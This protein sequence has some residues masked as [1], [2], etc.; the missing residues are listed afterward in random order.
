MKIVLIMTDSQGTNVLGCYGAQGCRTPNIDRLAEEGVRFERAYTTCPVCSPARGALFTGI[1]PHANGCWGNSMPLAEN[2]RTIGERLSEAGY[3]NAYIGKWHLDAFDYFGTGECPA[4]W[5]ARYWYD[6]RRYLEELTPEQRQRSRSWEPDPGFGAELTFAHRC[7]D[8][9]IDFLDKYADEDFMLVVSYDEPHGPHK[10]PV[11]YARMYDDFVYPRNP[12]V[13]DT[14]ENKPEHQRAWAEYLKIDPGKPLR[15]AT[16]FGCNTFVDHE[17]GRVLDAVSRQAPDAMVIFTSDHGYLL[18]AHRLFG[19][20]PVMYDEATRI[21]LIIRWPGQAAA[22][23]VQQTPTTHIDIVPTVLAAA[24]LDV[25]PVLDGEPLVD[26]L[27]RATPRQRT[28]FMEFNRFAGQGTGTGGLIPIRCAFDGQY[29]LVINLFYTDELY[30]LKADPQELN[31]LIGDPG[32]ASVRTRLHDE[33]LQWMA[34]SRD[35]FAGWQW[36]ARPWRGQRRDPWWQGDGRKP[37]G[38]NEIREDG[39]LPR[40]IDYR[41]GLSV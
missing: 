27:R 13:D 29:K 15:A 2:I 20:G 16:Y 37:R 5:D 21:P 35:P 26:E 32:L 25:P 24:G 41:T 18:N 40:P 3:H 11:E 19:K 30:N 34:D 12:N 1:Y 36:E 6:M 9:A 10:C 17:I 39:Y 4:G 22:G 8:R 31:N 28:V 14:L 33:I 23:A 7:S 38:E